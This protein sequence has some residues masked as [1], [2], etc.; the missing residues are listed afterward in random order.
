MHEGFDCN[1]VHLESGNL[2]KYSRPIVG[3][4]LMLSEPST[5]KSITT[6][7]NLNEEAEIAWEVF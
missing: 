3:L 5:F 7:S 2:V 4:I 6:L 1:D